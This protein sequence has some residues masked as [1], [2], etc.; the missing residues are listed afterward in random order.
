[1]GKTEYVNELGLLFGKIDGGV[2][3]HYEGDDTEPAL[4]N[5]IDEAYEEIAEQ[6]IRNGYSPSQ[7]ERITYLVSET[8]YQD[9]ESEYLASL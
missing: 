5:S 9:Q 2:R 7:M 4:F 3:V 8:E 1:M 6:G